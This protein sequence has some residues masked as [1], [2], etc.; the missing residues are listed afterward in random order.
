MAHRRRRRRVGPRERWPV[1]RH[2]S[3]GWATRHPS[4]GRGRPRDAPRAAPRALPPL[5]LRSSVCCLL[6]EALRQGAPPRRRCAPGRTRT[7]DL[8]IRR[9]LLYPLSYGGHG[10]PPGCRRQ[11]R[12]AA[13]SA[14]G[15]PRQHLV[16][17]PVAPLARQVR[18]DD[19]DLRRGPGGPAYVE[20]TRTQRVASSARGEPAQGQVRHERPTLRR[21][22]GHRAGRAHAAR[23]PPQRASSASADR[24]DAGPEHLRPGDVREA[25]TVQ[26]PPAR[27]GGVRAAT[28]ATPSTT[29]STTRSG[30]DPMNARVR[31]HWAGDDHRS[32][33]P[34][35]RRTARNSSRCSTASSG[36]SIDTNSRMQDII[37]RAPAMAGRPAQCR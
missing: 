17:R 22:P 13:S 30:A 15:E 25:P 34:D 37:R 14:E 2:G 8:E 20:S 6:P 32:S 10:T 9:L 28:A 29:S 27:A 18:R 3:N 7:C 12:C 24:V 26:R 1:A 21:R 11:C 36:G 5:S 23:Q 4:P 19:G 35:D 33:G 16:P 31:C